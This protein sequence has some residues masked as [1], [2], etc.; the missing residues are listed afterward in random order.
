VRGLGK[1]RL[2]RRAVAPLL[3][4]AILRGEKRGFSVPM[5]AWLRGELQPLARDLLSPDAM[6]R[7]DFFRPEAAT[8][9]LDEHVAGRAD[10]SRKIWALLVF[11]LWLERYGAGASDVPQVAAAAS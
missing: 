9:L 5:A 4:D 7:M 2:L 11:A 6:R 8:R 1:K 10:H 3:P